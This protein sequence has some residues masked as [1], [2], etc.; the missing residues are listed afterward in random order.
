MSHNFLPHEGVKFWTPA[1]WAWIGGLYDVLMPALHHG[2]PI[3]CYRF[4]KF[5]PE[6]AFQLIEDLQ[7][8]NMFLPPTAMKMMATV[9]NPEIRWNLNVRS[10][11]SGGESLGES[12][13]QWGVKTFGVKMNEFYGQ[14][15]CNMI[16]SACSA[17]MET[18]TG[19]MGKAAPGHNIKIIDADGNVLPPNTEGDIAVYDDSPTKMI[20]YWKNPQ[21]T[22]DKYNGHW[23]LTGDKG[24]MD[25]NDFIKFVGRDDDVITS[26]GY[27]IGPG[28][29]E[30]CLIRHESV[31]MVA[32]IG[33]P[34]DKRT[35]IVKAFII[36]NEG[37]EPSERLKED[38]A[39][40]VKD[41]LSPHEYPREIEFIDEFPMTT[42][43]KIQRK[44]LSRD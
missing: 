13:Q 21:A 34:D 4:K 6:E 35:E 40:Y 2:T 36:L 26:S 42:T 9:E 41:K 24:E 32:V 20:N 25:E 44:Q 17:I 14:T 7:I 12:I 28:E 43:G 19:Y 10:I 11:A 31:N 3:V 18:P 27:R 15:E 29:I 23:L 5:I 33:K 16:V 22:E 37:Y 30:D 8:R 1:D 38:I 39:L